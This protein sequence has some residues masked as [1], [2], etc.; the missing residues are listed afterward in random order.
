[1]EVFSGSS[2]IV[3]TWR[4]VDGLLHRLKCSRAVGS[5]KVARVREEGKEKSEER[6]EPVRFQKDWIRLRHLP[7][8]YVQHDD[9]RRL[10]T[11]LL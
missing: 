3:A 9:R 5:G 6:R 10:S 11:R 1:M 7:V 8:V 4:A 2:I